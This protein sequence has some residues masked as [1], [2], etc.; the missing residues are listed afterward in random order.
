M[1]LFFFLLYVANQIIVSEFKKYESIK[2]NLSLSK[3]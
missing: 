1:F 2:V 3:Y